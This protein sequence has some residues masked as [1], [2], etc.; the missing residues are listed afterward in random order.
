[1]ATKKIAKSKKAGKPAQRAARKGRPK[2]DKA[3]GTVKPRTRNKRNDA[4][5]PGAQRKA[6]KQQTCIDLLSR[7]NGAGIE[8]LQEATGWQ[9]HSVRGFLAGTV[10]KKLGLALGSDKPEDG[11]RRYRILRAKA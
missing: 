9:A 3:A 8:E 11:P 1:M 6:T 2:A 10:K 4:R 7:P 5:A